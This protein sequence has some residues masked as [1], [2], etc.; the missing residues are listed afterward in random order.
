MYSR[1][2][3]QRHDAPPQPSAPCSYTTPTST[4]AGADAA[5][6][7]S[8]PAVSEATELYASV[9]KSMRTLA[10]AGSTSV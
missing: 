4:A 2:S 3:F 7:D 10:P 6:G 1:V 9:P 8:A 5:V